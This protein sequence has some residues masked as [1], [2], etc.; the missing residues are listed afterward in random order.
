MGETM[1]WIQRDKIRAQVWTG[2]TEAEDNVA[3]Y[4]Y[5]CINKSYIFEL[6]Q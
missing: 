1:G 6:M 5:R 4:L 2:L 3:G